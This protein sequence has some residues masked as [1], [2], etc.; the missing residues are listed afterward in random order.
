MKAWR[1]EELV[2]SRTAGAADSSPESQSP[3]SSLVIRLDLILF[4]TP[5]DRALRVESLISPGD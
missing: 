3:P 4:I 2:F 1:C 5:R